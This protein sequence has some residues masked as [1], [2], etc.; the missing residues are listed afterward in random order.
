MSHTPRYARFG[1]KHSDFERTTVDLIR[2]K[3]VGY[4]KAC[5]LHQFLKNFQLGRK[6]M[7]VQRLILIDQ[8]KFDIFQV[9]KH[10]EQCCIPTTTKCRYHQNH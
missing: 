5:D 2:L 3:F 6:K 8:V 7:L 1:C 4:D 9:Q 10:G